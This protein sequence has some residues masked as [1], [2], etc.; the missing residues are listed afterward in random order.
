MTSAVKATSAVASRYAGALIDLAEGKKAIKK[1]EKD[2][3]ELSSMINGSDDLSSL[4]RSP[5][6]G[7]AQ[8]EKALLALAKKAKFQDLTMNF[9]GVLAQNGRVGALE[10][11][12][13][14]FYA[15][16][17]K[18]RG[19]VAVSVQVAQDLSAAQKK[20]LEAAISKTVGSDVMLDIKVEPSIL[21]GM[22]VTVGSQMIDD[23]VVRKLERLQSAMSKQSNENLMNL[24]EA[25]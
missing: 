6:V 2:L 4:V 23:S 21:G 14:A 24:K 8:Q 19:E 17:S 20:A 13:E 9:L 10:S 12:I 18:R 15:E 5:I 11:I 1:V 7:Q 22:I 16:V 25:K 3:N